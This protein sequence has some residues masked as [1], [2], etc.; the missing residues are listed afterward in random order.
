MSGGCVR[1]DLEGTAYQRF[2][3]EAL[4]EVTQASDSFVRSKRGGKRVEDL[5]TI[6]SK[7]RVK[8][9]L[10]KSVSSNAAQAWFST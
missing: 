5:E 3:D 4:L 9:V 2:E 1:L 7:D 6:F 10:C 8:N